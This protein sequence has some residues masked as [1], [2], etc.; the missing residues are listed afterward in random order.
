MG[1]FQGTLGG[2]MLQPFPLPKASSSL[3]LP[4]DLAIAG[5]CTGPDALITLGWGRSA[6]RLLSPQEVPDLKFSPQPTLPWHPV[7][8]FP[9]PTLEIP[10][11]GGSAGPAWLLAA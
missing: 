4:L 7:I 2:T 11:P 9:T 8:D 5:M 1:K 3:L 6:D 10:F